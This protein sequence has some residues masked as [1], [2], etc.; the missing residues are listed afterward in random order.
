MSE[1]TLSEKLELFLKGLD[2]KDVRIDEVDLANC[3]K[4]IISFAINEQSPSAAIHLENNR[5]KRMELIWVLG[6]IEEVKQ[7]FYGIYGTYKKQ[8]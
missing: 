2:R 4:T 5:R 7:Q 6:A 8:E 3:I 1:P